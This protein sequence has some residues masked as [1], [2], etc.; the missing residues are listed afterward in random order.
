[1]AERKY[2]TMVH[3]IIIKSDFDVERGQIEIVVGGE[4]NDETIDIVES[5][6]GTPDGNIITNLRLEKGKS[7]IVEL[8]FA[9]EMKHAIKLTAYEFK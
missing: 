4:E 6:M 3:S 5:S 9:D 1:M 8:K 2:G 7:N